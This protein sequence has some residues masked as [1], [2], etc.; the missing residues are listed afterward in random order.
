MA[1]RKLFAGPQL[2]R[3]RRARGLTQVA[4]AE[5]LEISASY[6]NLIERNQRPVTASILMRLAAVWDVDLR[7]LSAD[8]TESGGADGLRRRLAHPL[9]ADLAVDR[10]EVDEV[11]AAAP[12]FGDAFARLFDRWA[13]GGG[14]PDA[15]PPALTPMA[16]VDAAIARW[17]GHFPDL[18]AQAEGLA[19]EL[20][21]ATGDLQAAIIERL[22]VRH[23]L[24]VRI[25]P[26]SVM[27]EQLRRLDLHA[28]QLHL[29]ELLEP[30]SRTFEA[31][32]QLGLMEAKAEIDA[33]VAGADLV[34]RA[35]DRL[36]RRHLAAY[37]AAALIMP[38]ARFHRACEALG[39]DVALLQRRFAT[40][41][42]QVAHR[43]TTLQR[44]GL[45][46]LPFFM[47]RI[48]RAARVSKRFPGASDAPLAAE[49]GGCA[50][51]AIHAAFDRPATPIDQL[52]ETEDGRRWFTIAAAIPPR[53]V[54]VGAIRAEH[55]VVLGVAAEHEA[56]LA[57]RR[58][59]D[60]MADAA[61]PIGLDCPRCVRPACP[62]RATP[63]A[64]RR[65]DIDE[66]AR[67]AAPFPFTAD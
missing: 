6:L 61:M 46:G 13:A 38:Y 21:L 26:V 67:P 60:R 50:L 35:A 9:F 51:W 58:G 55:V 17:R 34:D 41:L 11:M 12:G 36:L 63:P 33:V 66:R 64:G 62:Q 52:V 25:L 29:S 18:D 53:A 2:R 3:L 1:D 44:V 32:V 22:R 49:G 43:L 4:L 14:T 57:Y 42:E 39:Y 31:A 24:A 5:S 10:N 27:P 48:D 19:D 47:L 23:G 16:L 15:A 40:G 8:R 65:L 45:R 30:A 37:F 56:Q 54:P 28:R 20:R 59:R 7:D